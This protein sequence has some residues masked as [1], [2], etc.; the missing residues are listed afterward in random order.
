MKP[1]RPMKFEVT[2]TPPPRRSARDLK[3]YIEDAVA[4]WKGSYAPEDDLFYLDGD[5]VKVRVLR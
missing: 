4:T 3:M 1:R 2:L 5:S